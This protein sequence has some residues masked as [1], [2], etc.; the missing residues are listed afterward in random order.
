M[1]FFS[2]IYRSLRQGI[3]FLIDVLLIYNVVLVSGKQQNDSPYILYIYNTCV[4]YTVVPYYLFYI[5]QFV[6]VNPKLLIYLFPPPFSF[7]NLR[8]FS[9]SESVSILQLSSFV[10]F[11]LRFHILVILY[12]TCLSLTLFA[13][14]DNLQGQPCCCK[15]H[16]FILFYGQVI[17]HWGFPGGS[18][19]N[20]PLAKQQTW[21]P[22]LGQKDP[23]EKEVAIHSSIPAQEIPWTEELGGLQS[24]RSQRVRQD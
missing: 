12:D 6:S 3:H 21:V 22:S 4:C 13:W 17:F 14:Y 23:L 5:Q 2:V 20:N 11:F 16:D 9:M 19:I 15:W 1:H 8:L 18:V 24:M 7:S 10:Y